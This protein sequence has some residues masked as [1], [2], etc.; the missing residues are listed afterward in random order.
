MIKRI[1]LFLSLVFFGYFLSSKLFFFKQGAWENGASIVTS[2]TLRLAS[3]LASPFKKF[4][5]YYRSLQNLHSHLQVLEQEREDLLQENIKL[6]ATLAY[7]KKNKELR[8]F[9][10]RYKLEDALSAKILTKTMTANE[11]TLIVNRGSR[12]GVKK[13]MAALY[14]FQLLGRISEVLPWYSKIMLITDR[15][16]KVSAHTNISN[17]PGVVEG[18]NK[19]NSCPL[20]YV[21][22]LAK[23]HKNDLIFSSGQGLVFPEGFC[24]GRIKTIETQGVCHTIDIEPLV[25]FRALE[26]CHLTNIEK[27]NLF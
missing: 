12:H 18:T 19:I 17:A 3:T 13:N 5:N 6:K 15:K 2:P 21:S 27:M 8:E 26:V 22:H 11:Q 20:R 9:K 16:S 25:D 14:K 24:L 23:V 10:K 7:D 4:G 1:L